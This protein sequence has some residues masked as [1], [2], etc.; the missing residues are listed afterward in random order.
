MTSSVYFLCVNR[1]WLMAAETGTRYS[2]AVDTVIH[3]DIGEVWDVLVNP[4]MAGELFWGT[5]VESDF[6][7]GSPI[8]WK[9]TWEGKP[10]EDRGIIKKMENQSILQYSHWSPGSSAPPE[11]DRNL[12]TIRLARE[13]AGIRVTLQHDNIASVTLKEHS[14]KNWK[15]LLE[16]L[17]ELAERGKKA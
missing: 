10:F 8:V 9:G 13:P 5:T 4:R 17:K 6:K 16:R 12:I 11:A 2:L 1:R 15:Q 7:V 3:A 14:E